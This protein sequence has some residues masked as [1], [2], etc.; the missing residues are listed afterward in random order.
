MCSLSF[1]VRVLAGI[2]LN[3][4][5]IA[6]SFNARKTSNFVLKIVILKNKNVF[7]TRHKDCS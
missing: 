5:I 6:R 3:G 4:K 7:G 2:C 1:W